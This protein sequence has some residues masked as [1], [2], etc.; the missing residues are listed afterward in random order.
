MAAFLPNPSIA[1]TAELPPH[2][3]GPVGPKWEEWQ[4]L[5]PAGQQAR[6]RD[7]IPDLE[8]EE[9]AELETLAEGEP[10]HEACVSIRDTLRPFLQGRKS[11]LYVAQG[12]PIIY[13]GARSFSPDIM[14]VSEVPLTAQKPRTAW[15][16]LE[17]GR[18]LDLVI[19]VHHCGNWRKVFVDNVGRYALLGIREYFAF[20]LDKLTLQGFRLPEGGASYERLHPERGRLHS[21]VLD[22]DLEIQE[23][24]LR[25]F[26][27]TARL[28]N[29][30]ERF[31]EQQ[32][33]TEQ[34]QQRADQ[35]EQHTEQALAALAD[36]ILKVL[37]LR[38]VVIDEALAEQV[39]TCRDQDRLTAWLNLAFAAPAA[40]IT[41]A[42]AA[43]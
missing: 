1:L 10:H 19:E 35:E 30:G 34:E 17:E 41:A 28:P 40:E 26:F 21:H 11:M 22:M 20:S 39:R 24:Q 25:F 5:T 31:V 42:L 14:A 36:A 7:L 4:A 3:A 29:L 9:I 18:G 27:S 32:Q 8:A 37:P 43:P 23:G 13:P 16:V 2:Y 33:R 38:Q 12:I 6:M 15:H